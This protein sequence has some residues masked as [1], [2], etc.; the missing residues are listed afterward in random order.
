MRHTFSNEELRDIILK[1]VT[2][3][4][5]PMC[6]NNGQEWWDGATGLGASPFPP[7]GVDPDDL[8]HGDCDNCAGLAF[9]QST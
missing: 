9:I 8:A 2:Y 5:C 6:D 7:P 4:K 3:E 1:K